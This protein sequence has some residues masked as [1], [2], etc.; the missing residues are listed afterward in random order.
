LLSEGKLT[1]KLK[2]LIAVAV[3]HMTGCSH[4]ID[5]HVK[6]VK[7]HRASKE[8]MAESIMVATALKTGSAMAHG[9]NALVAYDE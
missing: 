8:E 6:Q 9:V 4:C 1:A 7:K 2:E 3:A 5:V